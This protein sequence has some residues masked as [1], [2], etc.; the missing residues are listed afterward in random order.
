[1]L[2]FLLA[3]YK[4]LDSQKKTLILHEHSNETRK[5]KN[6]TDISNI[7]HNNLFKIKN[8]RD[9]E[10]KY[11]EN[12]KFR[13]KKERK[14]QISQTLHFQSTRISVFFPDEERIQL[15]RIE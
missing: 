8:Q 11:M 6:E 15:S 12:R 3:R 14:K 2:W 13:E 4:N 5:K 7:E 1:M 9:N 10:S